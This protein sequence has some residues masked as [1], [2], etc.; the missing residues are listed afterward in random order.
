MGMS[1][2][3]TAEINLM[4]NKAYVVKDGVLISLPTPPTGYGQQTIHWESEKVTRIV[5]GHIQKV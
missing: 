2:K 4:E 5:H 3:I 1:D